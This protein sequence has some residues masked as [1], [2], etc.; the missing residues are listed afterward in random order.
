MTGDIDQLNKKFLPY[1]GMRF[2]LCC[3]F[4]L[5]ENILKGATE[6]TNK[7]GVSKISKKLEDLIKR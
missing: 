2:D 7:N 1:S 6:T 5:S 4:P 3:L